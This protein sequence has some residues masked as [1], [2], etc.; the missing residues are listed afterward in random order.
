MRVFV[1][2]WVHL[3]LFVTLASIVPASCGGDGGGDHSSDLH[4]FFT[5]GDPVCMGHQ[6]HGVEPCTN[7]RAGEPCSPEGAR[8]DPGNSCDQDLLCAT[9]D[10]TTGPG[11]CPI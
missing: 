2:P 9:T 6:D 4:W 11:G 10:P 8:C 3:S 1:R 5:C 7:E